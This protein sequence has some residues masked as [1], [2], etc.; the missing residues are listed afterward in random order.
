[1]ITPS[2]ALGWGLSFRQQYAQREKHPLLVIKGVKFFCSE[3]GEKYLSF[4]KSSLAGNGNSAKSL[5][6][7]ASLITTSLSLR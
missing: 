3:N 6:A 1:M 2:I 5:S 4:D 7:G